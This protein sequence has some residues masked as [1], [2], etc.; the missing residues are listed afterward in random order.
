MA[1]TDW[2]CAH[3]AHKQITDSQS[4]TDSLILTHYVSRAHLFTESVSS[5]STSSPTWARLKSYRETLV[6]RMY[7]CTQTKWATGPSEE[8]LKRS[9]LSVIIWK[10]IKY[11]MP[12]NCPRAGAASWCEHNHEKGDRSEHHCHSQSWR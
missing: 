10:W 1:S 11:E 3:M 2:L 9:L 4:I 12:I 8:A 5:I 6:T 7:T